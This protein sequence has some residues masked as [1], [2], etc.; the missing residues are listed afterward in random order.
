[1]TVVVGGNSC[2]PGSVPIRLYKVDEDTWIVAG[3]S[4]E[5]SRNIFQI[6]VDQADGL[7]WRRNSTRRHNIRPGDIVISYPEGTCGS[8]LQHGTGKVSEDGELH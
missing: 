1:M 2:Q 7:Y 8:V 4:F 6:T 5:G 3:L